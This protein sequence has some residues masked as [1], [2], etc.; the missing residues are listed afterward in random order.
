M[1]DV[2]ISLSNIQNIKT[3]NIEGLGLVKAR[4]LGAGEE[5]DLLFKQRRL[6]KILEE[7]DSLDFTKID[8]SKKSGINKAKELSDRIDK[9]TSEIE[10]IKKFELETF[11]RCFTDDKNGEIVETLI[12]TLTEEER[13]AL[14]KEI[15]GERKTLEVPDTTEPDE[16]KSDA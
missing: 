9:L 4:K 10:E 15:F 6:G 1:A 2:S 3:V 8:T 16:V 11:R 7:L 14:F 12:Q 5:L 13:M